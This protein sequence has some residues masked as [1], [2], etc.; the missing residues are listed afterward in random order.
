MGS[1]PKSGRGT[2]CDPADYWLM[3]PGPGPKPP[4]RGQ[5]IVPPRIVV[6]QEP[7]VYS[8]RF[9]VYVEMIAIPSCGGTIGIKLGPHKSHG[10]AYRAAE[11]FISSDKAHDWLKRWCS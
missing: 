5:P 11:E 1:G 9:F 3:G 6:R 8:D 10:I 2:L 4:P 7:S